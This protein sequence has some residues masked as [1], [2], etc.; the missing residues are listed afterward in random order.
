MS[1]YYSYI[2][3]TGT[4]IPDTSTLLSDVTTEYQAVFGSDLVTDPSTPQG[5]L[6][7]AE[8][9]ARSSVVNNN[10]KLANNINPNIAGGV[11]LDAIGFL[12]GIQRTEQTQT[13]VTNVQLNGAAGTIIPANSQASTAAGDIF[14][15][16]AQVILNGAGVAH[17][18][19]YSQAYGPIP[20]AANALVNVVS[21]VLGWETVINS[22]SITTLGQSTQSDQQFRAYRNNTLGFQ[23]VGLAVAITSALYAVPGVESLAY[24]ENYY[25]T[26]M[27]MLISITS[28]STLSGQIWGMTTTSGTGTNG[29]IIV[30]TDNMAFAKSLQS[31]PSV[32][33][34]PVANFGTTGNIT[35]SGL[36]T[37]AGGDWASGLTAGNIILVTA[38]T[39]ASQNGV[40]VA[41]SGSWTRHA[42]NTSGATILP[43]N[44][45]IS[46]IMNSIYTCVQGGAQTNIA[47][48]LLE[49]KSSGCAWN[50]ITSVSV[51]EPASGQVYTVLYDTPTIVNVLIK[52]TTT[53]GNATN[54]TQ[55]IL[56]YAA[57]NIQGFEGF[58]IGNS[59]SPFEISAAIA[60]EYPQYYISNVQLSY[61]SPISYSNS[62]IPIGQ[63]QVAAT[64]NSLIT[65]VT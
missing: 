8:A 3:T 15:S 21:S 45:G 25:S 65:V 62:V 31:L 32:N 55:A 44:Q 17:V 52:V 34:W 46:L 11:F 37:Q 29:G 56:D 13:L 38:Q 10:A 61:T 47:A 26:P 2:D 54:I 27:G 7:T 33:P 59:V 20:C 63:N 50:G 58:V 28:G 57:G 6:I 16:A 1:N 23:S 42:Y 18:N 4:V 53:N 35:L 14:L 12:T 36:S 43:S 22:A 51:T 41:A 19:F 60:A 40:W 30:A 48:A 9:L 39:T 24:L 49:N 5:V 64:N